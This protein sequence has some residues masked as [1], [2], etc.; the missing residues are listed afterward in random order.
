MFPAWYVLNQV[1]VLAGKILFVHTLSPPPDGPSFARSRYS[2]PPEFANRR[3]LL[4]WPQSRSLETRLSRSESIHL[5]RPKSVVVRISSG[6]NDIIQGRLSLRA[7]SAGLRLHT[8]QA[9]IRSGKVAITD[10]SQPGSI[11]FGQFHSDIT[12]DI[13]VPYSL[14]SDLKEIVV[15]AEVTY[16]TERGE[17]VYACSSKTSTALPI[18]ISVRDTFKKGAIFSTFTVGTAD[19]TPVKILKC[20]VEGNED[21]CATSP[22][23]DSGGHDIFVRQPFSLASRIQRTLR[24]KGGLDANETIQRKLCLH[25]EYRCLDQEM[26]TAAENVYSKA[27]AA[28]PLQKL[29]RLLMPALLTTLR[30]RL[31]TSQLEVAG[32]LHEMDIGTFEDYGWGSSILAGLPPDL[33]EELTRWLRDWHDVRVS[34]VIILNVADLV[35]GSSDNLVQGC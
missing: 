19:A 18:T 17:F 9:E 22:T 25:V 7:A 20:T 1:T 10:K 28:T 31:S 30:S 15:R 6:W 32:L 16:A 8:A 29:S 21:F 27:L 13:D 5:E 35:P 3:L 23:L 2:A 24:G 34:D 33:G 14:E 12:V 11:A 4:L 26:L